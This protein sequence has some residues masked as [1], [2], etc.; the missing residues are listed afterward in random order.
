[1][2]KEKSK[3][4][5]RVADLVEE[6]NE[7]DFSCKA[8]D[9]EGAELSAAGFTRDIQVNVVAEKNEGEV[10]ITL[11]TS[12]LADFTC[13]ICLAPISRRLSGSLKLYYVIGAPFEE[14]QDWNKEYR[15][16]D[17]SAE[18]IDITGD[19]FETLLLSLPL[20]VTCTDNPDCKLYGSVEQNKESLAE[21]INSWQES[22]EKLK[23]KYR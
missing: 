22:L 15:F 4:A 11:K 13:D 17:K 7:F 19:V 3:I 5:I 10:I 23:N 14:T 12:T 21:E 16:L 1:M 20:K 6:I 2:H 9:F 18:S 8:S